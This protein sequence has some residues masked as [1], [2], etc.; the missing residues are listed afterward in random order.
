MVYMGGKSRLA[1]Y[2][3]PIMLASRKE[4]Q[5]YVEPFAGGMNMIDKVDGRRWAN[6]NNIYLMAMWRE[7]RRGWNPPYYTKEQYNDI[8]DN[9]AKYPLHEVGYV[10]FNCS[11]KGKFFNGYAGYVKHVDRDY[12]LEKL[13]NIQKQLPLLQDVTFTSFDYYTMQISD[14][15]VYCDPPYANTTEYKDIFDSKLFFEWARN[16]S[17]FRNNTVFIS[18]YSAPED[19]ECVYDVKIKSSLAAVNGFGSTQSTEKLFTLR[20]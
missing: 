18:E 8:R 14:S 6:D 17:I 15:I 20:K 10:G 19:F 16:I 3:L 13:R 12:Q 4:N 2:Y 7:L 5:L 11:F 1:K 9:K